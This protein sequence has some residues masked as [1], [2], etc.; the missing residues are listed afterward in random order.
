[1]SIILPADFGEAFEGEPSGFADPRPKHDFIAQRGGR[2]VIDFVSQ[3]DPAN[4]L[5]SVGA[6]DRLPMRDRDILDPAQVNRIVHM[7]LLV[8][9]VWLNRNGHFESSGHEK[10]RS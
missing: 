9:I 7:V 4:C 6:G 3:H 2:F 1:L 10:V 5:L 8:N